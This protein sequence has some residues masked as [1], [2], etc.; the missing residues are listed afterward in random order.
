M[1]QQNIMKKYPSIP[2]LRSGAQARLPRFAFDYLDGGAG[3]E[4]CGMP[5]LR[6]FAGCSVPTHRCLEPCHYPRP[7]AMTGQEQ[8]TYCAAAHAAFTAAEEMIAKAGKWSR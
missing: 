6:P 8:T 5:C 3:D 7:V 4:G 1:S 2:D